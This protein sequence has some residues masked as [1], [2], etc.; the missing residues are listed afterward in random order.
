MY[1]A[2]VIH[3]EWL[4]YVALSSDAKPMAENLYRALWSWIICVLV[5]IVVSMFTTRKPA[6]E[7]QGLVYA[8]TEIPSDGDV[9]LYKRPIFWGVGVAILFAILQ[10][11][12]W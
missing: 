11:L 6:A 7:L 1:T 2:V 8:Y 3:P 5:T 12:F 9:P 10:F 4:R